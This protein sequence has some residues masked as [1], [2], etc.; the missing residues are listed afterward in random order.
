METDHA[1]NFALCVCLWPDLFSPG[2][3]LQFLQ[4]Q[5]HSDWQKG[6]WQGH[7]AT[8]EDKA[9]LNSLSS[10]CQQQLGGTGRK[11]MFNM[12]LSTGEIMGLLFPADLFGSFVSFV[13]FLEQCC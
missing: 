6:R 7:V 3:L 2:Y 13:I 12:F 4:F 9:A 5:K 10:N 8:E 1:E 11:A